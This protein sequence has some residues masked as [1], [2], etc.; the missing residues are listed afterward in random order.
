MVGETDRIGVKIIARGVMAAEFV[1]GLS[2]SP[3]EVFR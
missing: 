2:D 1:M 3:M